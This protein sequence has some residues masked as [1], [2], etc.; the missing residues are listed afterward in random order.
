MHYMDLLVDN[1]LCIS[2]LCVCVCV[3]VC[4]WKSGVVRGGRWFPRARL[5]G[6][7]HTYFYFR[8]D[9]NVDV[10]S[11]SVRDSSRRSSVFVNLLM[12]KETNVSSACEWTERTLVFFR[13]QFRRWSSG[14]K[15]RGGK[16]G[17]GR[18]RMVP[19]LF[20]SMILPLIVAARVF[21]HLLFAFLFSLL[22]A[23]FQ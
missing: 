10:D 5:K 13:F 9:D 3:C 8:M 14:I 16:A 15:G 22:L 6:G 1:P 21:L 12:P 18:E 2:F 4:V 7:D 23:R 20:H 19:L 11:V 17:R